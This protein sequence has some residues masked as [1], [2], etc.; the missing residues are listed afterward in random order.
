MSASF[1]RLFA[2]LFSGVLL[3]ASSGCI[4]FGRTT[5]NTTGF[6]TPAERIAVLREMRNGGNQ[7]TSINS[8]TESIRK[9]NDVL[10]RAEIVRTAGTIPGS[11]AD[12]LLQTAALED[13]A[14][15]VR[16]AAC[17]TLGNRGGAAAVEPLALA[18][19]RLGPCLGRQGPGHP[20]TRGTLAGKG[21]R[22]EPRRQRLSLAEI[23][24][25][26]T[27]A[28]R[29]RTLNRR[30]LPLDVLASSVESQPGGWGIAQRC[31]RM[32]RTGASLRSAASHPTAPRCSRILRDR[33]TVWHGSKRR[34]KVKL[35][36][37]NS[38]ASTAER[39]RQECLPYRSTT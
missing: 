7:A 4:D 19:C 21:Q 18:N 10:I 30:T 37:I 26:R 39:S 24:Q 34:P 20:A 31:P 15:E 23:R 13:P 38:A 35:P 2:A 36:E 12:S 33:G 32:S 5:T 16:V 6:T 1:P 27:A 17:E 29:T 9:E 22:Q 11:E 14:N 3:A 25:R 8:L 28:I